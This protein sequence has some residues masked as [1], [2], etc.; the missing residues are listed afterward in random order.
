MQQPVQIDVFFGTWCSYC[1]HFLPGFMK[2]IEA[3]ANKSITVRYIGVSEDMSEPEAA[4][5]AAAVTR[6]PTFVIS[7]GGQEIGRIVEKPKETIEEDLAL[8]LMGGR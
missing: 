7:S 4:L 8:L 2:T 3:A 6:T 5:T 1:K